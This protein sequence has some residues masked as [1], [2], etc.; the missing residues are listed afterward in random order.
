MDKD[1]FAECLQFQ[2]KLNCRTRYGRIFFP[3]AMRFI[4]L[5]A[6]AHGKRSSVVGKSALSNRQEYNKMLD[7]IVTLSNRERDT[8]SAV[9]TTSFKRS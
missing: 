9:L 2:L 3:S 4:S 8:N 5:A 7:F 6:F 1:V